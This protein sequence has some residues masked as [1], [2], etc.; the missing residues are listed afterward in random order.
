[1]DSCCIFYAKRSFMYCGSPCISFRRLLFH[2]SWEGFST[3]SQPLGNVDARMLFFAA[4]SST[5]RIKQST[6]AS[7]S[8]ELLE[9]GGALFSRPHQMIQIVAKK[10]SC[11][12]SCSDFGHF[13]LWMFCSKSAFLHKITFHFCVLLLVQQYTGYP[14]A[15]QTFS[16]P[17]TLSLFMLL[18]G[19]LVFS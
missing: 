1:M 17:T 10:Q 2:K 11:K 8:M 12:K 4:L 16:V 14:H 3:E 15:P 9:L 7:V 19:P 6:T 5:R 18:P 13:G